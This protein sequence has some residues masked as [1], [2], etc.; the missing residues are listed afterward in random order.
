MHGLCKSASDYVNIVLVVSLAFRGEAVVRVRIPRVLVHVVA[1]T[2]HTNL[3]SSPFGPQCNFMVFVIK[4][5]PALELLFRGVYIRNYTV[6]AHVYPV[7]SSGIV[8]I[9]NICDL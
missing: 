9:H 3:L 7:F 4:R 2:T 5:P 1:T 6:F 8:P